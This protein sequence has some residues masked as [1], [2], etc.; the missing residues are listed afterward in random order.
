MS[1]T[2]DYTKPDGFIGQEHVERQ[3]D[4][5]KQRG[6]PV[7]KLANVLVP[8][9]EN[10]PLLY[11]GEILYRNGV[12]CSYIRTG[13]Y[14]HTVNGGVGLAMLE[15]TNDNEPITNQHYIKNAEWELD[16]AGT[17]YPCSVSLTPFY[18]PKNERI[19]Q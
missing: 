13:S 2:C 8:L 18:D 12:P 19:K 16:I 15:S 14:G 9:Q 3:R 7:R 1:F 10:D 11:H 5:N 6:G 17:R 4:M